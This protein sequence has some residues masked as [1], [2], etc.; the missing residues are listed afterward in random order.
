MCW[1]LQVENNCALAE[2][3]NCSCN[4]SCYKTGLKGHLLIRRSL[5]VKQ[6]VTANTECLVTCPAAD[7]VSSLQMSPSVRRLSPLVL[8]Y[9]Q[10]HHHHHHRTLRFCEPVQN[11]TW[12]FRKIW[13]LLHENFLLTV[14]K[15]IP[16]YLLVSR[17]FTILQTWREFGLLELALR[18]LI[19]QSLRALDIRMITKLKLVQS[20]SFFFICKTKILHLS[21]VQNSN[22][23]LR[24]QL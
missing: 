2:E 10:H 11:C 8:M 13:N 21:I 14:K 18:R 22:F 24:L 16:E 1:L 7:L 9:I 19:S 3:C 6:H 15:T 17:D 4:K 20:V 23:N 5:V 12:D